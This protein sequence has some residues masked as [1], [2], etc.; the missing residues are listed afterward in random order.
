MNYQDLLTEA[1]P[2]VLQIYDNCEF[3]MH[4]H[5]EIEIIYSIKGTFTIKTE[6]EEFP[7]NSGEVIIISSMLPHEAYCDRNSGNLVLLIKIGPAFL[8]NAFYEFASITFPNPVFNFNNT[9]ERWSKKLQA[10][11][12]TLIKNCNSR[13]S[14]SELTMMGNLYRL[15]ASIIS[16][17]P[18][19][20]KV[21]SSQY[22]N[23][24]NITRIENV[25]EYIYLHYG[26]VITVDKAAEI[27]G[28][29]VGNFC[30]V[31]KSI[32]GWSFHTY[33][34]NFRIKNAGFLLS[35]TTLSVSEISNMVGFSETKT[36]CRVFKDTIGITPTEY[37][38]L[39]Y[40]NIFK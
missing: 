22:N 19:E 5:H 16:D 35:E 39:S 7:V 11:F 32:T 9:A 18:D 30:K 14:V 15:C 8:R 37:R 34:N 21:I 20:R 1:F 17:I 13:E 27:A 25:L 26:E 6:T 2:Y 3:E 24:K 40:K 33:L 10:F 38:K 36:F 29:S 23:Y 12:K 31:F 28:Y 4:R